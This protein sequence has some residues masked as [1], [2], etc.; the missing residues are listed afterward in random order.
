MTAHSRSQDQGNS[1]RPQ[2]QPGDG[3]AEAT[4]RETIFELRWG[5]AAQAP[6]VGAVDPGFELLLGRLYERL[7]GDYPDLVN[8]PAAQLP[9]SHSAHTVRHQFRSAGR[10][11]PLVQIGPGVLTLNDAADFDWSRFG[12]RVQ[13]S[14]AE[15]F[16]TYPAEIHALRPAAVALRILDAT[17]LDSGQTSLLGVLRDRLHT[18]VRIDP[19]LFEDPRAAQDPS[20]LQFSISFPLG[21]RMGHGTLALSTARDANG[22][23]LLS[24]L[25][26]SALGEE[27]PK[28]PEAIQPWAEGA[29]KVLTRWLETLNGG[30]GRARIGDG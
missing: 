26:A 9:A 28:S 29:Q 24:Q 10:S 15:L 22:P 27:V 20:G 4:L 5:L 6:G 23:R 21:S 25:E 16:D 1:N 12:P 11:W 17:P 7:R 19:A 30:K 8:L 18:S 2:A 14:V 3:L 13:R